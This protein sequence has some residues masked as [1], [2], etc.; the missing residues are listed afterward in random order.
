MYFFYVF[1]GD[2]HLRQEYFSSKT[3]PS[4]LSLVTSFSPDEAVN[5]MKEILR[6]KETSVA[7]VNDTSALSEEQASLSITSDHVEDVV[8]DIDMSSDKDDQ[9]G[10]PSSSNAI[11]DCYRRETL[12]NTARA[13]L[14]NEQ[15]LV[16][17]D[18]KSK[19]FTVRSL[20]HQIVHAV[21]MNDH[22]RLFR[23][24]CPSIVERCA[25]VLAVK[26][27]LGIV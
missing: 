11:I 20:D 4:L 13:N 17:F 2:Y 12:T 24:S 10:I 19:V 26:V 23:C 8:E 25:H 7:Q 9:T 14:L 22:K 16:Q 15:D 3:H 1:T 5:R 27:Y 6:K 18:K 21:H